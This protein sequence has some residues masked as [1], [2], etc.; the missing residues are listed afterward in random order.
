M[1]PFSANSVKKVI[2]ISMQYIICKTCILEVVSTV[3][4]II[5]SKPRNEFGIALIAN[6]CSLPCTCDA[7]FCISF[8]ANIHMSVNI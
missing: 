8:I 5:I 3:K 2:A 1:E 7:S 6:E 4:C